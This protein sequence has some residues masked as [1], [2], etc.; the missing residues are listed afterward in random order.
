M[1]LEV[2]P[3][4]MQLAPRIK[5]MADVGASVKAIAGAMQLSWTAVADILHYT[6][7]GKLPRW[8]KRPWSGQACARGADRKTTPKYVRH[9]ERVGQLHQEGHA[10]TEIA[11]IVSQETGESITPATVSRAYY[12]ARA[13]GG[14]LAAQRLTSVWCLKPCRRID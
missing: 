1:K 5:A 6:R 10:F 2:E 7:T 11:K 12:H 3:Q 8:R 9:A 13:H 14:G 4:Y